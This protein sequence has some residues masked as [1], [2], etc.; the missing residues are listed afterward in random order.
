KKLTSQMHAIFAY[1][2]ETGKSLQLTDGLSDARFP[3]FDQKGQYL[4]FTASTDIG[5]TSGWLDLSSIDR[6]V[7]RSAYLIVLRK[8]QPSP[9]A[10]ESD[11]EKAGD[12]SKPDTDKP[13]GAKAE[14]EQEPMNPEEKAKAADAKPARAAKAEAVTVKVDPENISQRILALP[15]PTR[16]YSGLFAGKAGTIFLVEG[17][18]PLARLEPSG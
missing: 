18:S 4:Y 16:D 1:S 10:P 2:L 8:D 15:L 7:T 5:P 13:A 3:A 14:G 12:E 17:D 11:E 9:L 6:P